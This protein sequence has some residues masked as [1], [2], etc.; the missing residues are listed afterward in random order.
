MSS[1]TNYSR[2]LFWISIIFYFLFIILFYFRWKITND[3]ISEMK[4]NNHEYFQKI[5]TQK[6][7]G[8]FVIETKDLNKK[9]VIIDTQEVEKINNHINN[10]SEKVY[11][12]YH[13]AEKIINND[14]DR[15]N[16][17]MAI[18]IGFMTIL[19]VFVPILMN[20]LNH[21]DLREK[22]KQ[23]ITEQRELTNKIG[24]VDTKIN[25]IPLEK[26]ESAKTNSETAISKSEEAL[27]NSGKVDDLTTKVEGVE[28]IINE[29]FPKIS[30]L[31]L[32]SAI[33]RYFN[34]V[35]YLQ[36]RRESDGEHFKDL[37]ESIKN[38]FSDCDV[39]GTVSIITDDYYKS[40]IKDFI[41][42]I[43][44]PRIISAFTSRKTTNL[45]FELAE[46]LKKFLSSD[47]NNEKNNCLSITSKLDEIIKSID[48]DV[49]TKP[50]TQPS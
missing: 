2:P 27:Q 10:L 26:I 5:Q 17:Y 37:I 23:L 4:K 15:L 42:Y 29:S 38:R 13:R 14:I 40:I 3:E 24:E 9:Q 41:R 49:T 50:T 11:E 44:E 18:G 22:Q 20:L 21:H 45:F 35:P 28:K 47:K 39:E 46:V 30:T 19:G 16:T 8:P 48:N 43:E 12:E 7:H 25:E 6:N 32:Q 1:N 36:G 31:I 34:L 33:V